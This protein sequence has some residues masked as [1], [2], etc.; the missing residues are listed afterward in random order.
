M[1]TTDFA[2]LLCSRLC[3]DLVSP[4]G[5]ITNGLEL[6]VEEDDDDTR[7]QVVDL[8]NHSA[9]LAAN[10]LKFFRLAFG[11]SSGFAADLDM[12][13]TEAAAR[14]FIE[15]E[16]THITW[17]SDLDY[18]PKHI[19]KVLMNLVLVAS[20][21]MVRGGK[22]NV[23]ISFFDNKTDL[24]VE[25]ESDRLMVPE[26]LRSV[27]ADQRPDMDLLE[28]RTAPIFLIDSLLTSED[29]TLRFEE[30]DNRQMRAGVTFLRY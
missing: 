10:K 29:V 6:L 22:M 8:L 23:V 11:A 20:E 30:P 1:A 19:V 5:A 25:A 15:S 27:M 17:Q 2:A 28:A 14:A 24:L 18:A 4:V 21:S 13:E 26:A 16:S 7:E 3:H 12:R 9:A